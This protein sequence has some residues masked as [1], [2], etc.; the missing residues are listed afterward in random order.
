VK[1]QERL[2]S[3]LRNVYRL[4]DFGQPIL[5]HDGLAAGTPIVVRTG[6]LA[7]M[8]GTIVRSAGGN[9]F[10]VHIDLIQRG[11]AVVVDAETLGRLG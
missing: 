11:V 2:W 1:D 4:L 6:P 5:P 10:V 8:N 9:K 7:G 3:D